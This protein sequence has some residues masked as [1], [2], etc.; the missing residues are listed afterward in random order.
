VTTQAIGIAVLLASMAAAQTVDKPAVDNGAGAWNGK[1]AVRYLDQRLEWWT[2][3]RTAARDHETFCVSCHTVLPYALGRPALR[4]ALAEKSESSTERKLLDNVIKRVRLWSEVQPFYTDEKNGAPKSTESRGTEAVLEALILAS[5]DSR[6]GRFSDD[7]R[8]AFENMWS[9]QLKTGDAMGAFPWLNFQNQPWE[10]DD[11]QFW[12]ATLGAIAAGYAPA[13][14]RSNTGVQANVEL[15]AAYLRRAAPGQSLI[16]RLFLLWASTKIPGLLTA[17]GHSAI[18]DEAFAKQREDGG[19][20]TSSLVIG[21]WKRKD[22]TP[23][24]TGSDGYGTGLVSFVLEQSGVARQ[25]PHLQH[26]LA[27]LRKNQDGALGLW[28]AA[29]L[30]KKRDPASDAGRFMSDAATAYSVLALTGGK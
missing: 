18:V 22:A 24:E 11:S 7:T 28:P 6:E 27:W 2:T 17:P 21:T 25:E 16:N 26:A 8:K 4:S 15:L 13:Q 29:S 10:A 1:A 12:G 3:W 23:L 20:S 14:Y 19:W 9:V 30:N 5:Y